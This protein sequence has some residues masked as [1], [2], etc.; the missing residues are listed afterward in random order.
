MS[1]PRNLPVFSQAWKEE[2]VKFKATKQKATFG[3]ACI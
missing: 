1:L 2:Y 3:A